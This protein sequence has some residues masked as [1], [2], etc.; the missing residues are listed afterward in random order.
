MR[1]PTGIT[2]AT[3]TS[4]LWRLA[5]E[6]KERAGRRGITRAKTSGVGYSILP[7]SW[8]RQRACRSRGWR[9]D[10][11]G[12]KD[13]GM[14]SWRTTGAGRE[15]G[16]LDDDGRE[17]LDR[18]LTTANGKDGG[19]A[20]ETVRGEAR[21]WASRQPAGRRGRRLFS[22]SPCERGRRGV[23]AEGATWI[24]GEDGDRCAV[25]RRRG[26]GRRRRIPP[27]QEDGASAQV[28]EGKGVRV[29]RVLWEAD[30][31]GW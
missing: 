15:G 16:A 24:H 2:N 25:D 26:W 28:G 14:E 17:V 11:R 10:S 3:S 4:I 6:G 20:C 27:R 12:G 22:A 8:S 13:D 29:N 21:F 31:V 9:R 30:E 19:W 23:W 18:R 5:R 1:R 7:P